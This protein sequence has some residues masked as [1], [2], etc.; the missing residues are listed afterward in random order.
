MNPGEDRRTSR[1]TAPRSR[2]I[3]GEIREKSPEALR[4]SK[5]CAYLPSCRQLCCTRTGSAVS[6]RPP[7]CLR[8]ARA[9]LGADVPGSRR[10]R[11]SAARWNCF[12]D[13][14]AVIDRLR[15]VP[16]VSS[17][18]HGMLSL[19][20]I[21]VSMGQLAATDTAPLKEAQ[22][23][24]AFAEQPLEELSGLAESVT[25]ALGGL[26]VIEDRMRAGAGER[27]RAGIRAVDHAARQDRAAHTN[28]AGA[29]SDAAR[30]GTGI[31]GSE[32]GWPCVLGH[33][34]SRDE[35]VRALPCRLTFVPMNRRVQCRCCAI[36]PSGW[37]RRGF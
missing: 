11:S 32:Q 29:R 7:S 6:G 30:D 24:D 28:T 5:D 37:C 22:I 1:R 19:R 26:H 18:Q 20:V 14:I 31:A 15:R 2:R 33:I 12:A 4:Q 9:L 21:E 10:R 13:P 8:M 3:G 34:G 35:A 25:A 23:K 27:R 16:L 17:R 36:A